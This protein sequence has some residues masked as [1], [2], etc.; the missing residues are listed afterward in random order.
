MKYDIYVGPILLLRNSNI[1]GKRSLTQCQNTTCA[2][3]LQKLDIKYKH[4]W[5]CGE[6]ME[7]IEERYPIVG[8]NIIDSRAYPECDILEYI[9][10]NYFTL[11]HDHE[12]ALVIDG[13]TETYDTYRLNDSTS[14]MQRTISLDSD[15]SQE[16]LIIDDHINTQYRHIFIEQYG[17]S[18]GDKLDD[19]IEIIGR[20]SIKMKIGISKTNKS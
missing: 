11:I 7:R 20:E 6:V 3:H 8:G 14:I 4:C 1:E 18:L 15:E 9:V 10:D 2:N 19:I 16:T 17:Q 12:E 13:I 5:E